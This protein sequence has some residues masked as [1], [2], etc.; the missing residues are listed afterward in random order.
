MKILI[1]NWR[2]IKN[3][4]AGGAEISLFE[5]A[6]Y[7]KK[8]GAEID[9]ISASF[10]S[11]PSSEIIDGIQIFR[12]GSVYTVHL[13]TLAKSLNGQ[14]KKYDLI[15]DSFHFVPYLSVLYPKT[16]KI[17]KVGLLNEVAG[18]LWF[19]NINYPMA[20]AGYILEPVAI[21]FY[22]HK[23]IITG[24]ESA[25]D[26]LIR[27]GTPA[28]NIHVVHHGVHITPVAKTINKEKKP[29]MLFLGRVSYDKGIRHAAAAFSKVMEKSP[30]AQFWIVGKE[31]KEGIF[32]KLQEQYPLL[33]GRIKYFGFVNENKKFELYR[34]AWVLIH[35]SEK[36]GWGLTVIEA[37]SQGTP[38]V[39][40][41]VEGLRDSIIDKET[42]I[43]ADS[44][45]I[46]SLADGVIR[47]FQDPDLY[48]M[49]SEN[50]IHWAK[51]FEWSKSVRKSWNILKQEFKKL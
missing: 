13:R 49:M 32:N 47:L 18:K 41:N 34:K 38:T 12:M 48:S 7:W 42:G 27:L 33:K 43:L 20:L 36:E 8:K 15:I 28:D 31:E 37:A 22:K 4:L 6:K 46:T 29:T 24:S 5:H 23:T 26:D 50:G 14:F 51:Q 44:G 17:P 9:W 19:S 2:D 10:N 35:P 39:G 11:A 25:R 3:P 16:S 45:S 30:K 1:L 21:R 40:Y